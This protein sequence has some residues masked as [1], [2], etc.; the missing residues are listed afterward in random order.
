MAEAASASSG[1]W[2]RFCDWWLGI[3]EPLDRVAR[4]QRSGV[5]STRVDYYWN[6]HTVNSEPFASPEASLAYLEWR[7][8]QYPLFRQ[9]MELYGDHKGKT[10]LDYG[11]GPGNDLVGFLLQSRAD[12]VIG[13]DVSAKALDLARQRL[14]LHVYRR[15]RLQLIQISD[16]TP[17]VPLKSR[18][19]DHVYCEGVLH[20]TSQPE[21]ILAEFQRVLRPGGSA[22]IMVYNRQS[23][24][25]HLYT[26]YMRQ[27]VRGDFAGLSLE[28]AFARNTDGPHCPISRCYA[29][30]EFSSLCQSCGFHVQ[31]RGGYLSKHELECL[32]QCGEAALDDPRLAEEHR[33]FLRGLSKDPHGYP[34]TEGK[35]AGIGGTYWLTKQ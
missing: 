27:V 30:P 28:E 6:E 21:A 19:V 7:F 14:G 26:A 2:R 4:I 32:D 8:E 11:C 31:Y 5:P 18:S 3:K 23:V 12:K 20:H 16:L 1:L 29:W 35:H 13:M 25:V 15:R 9:F 22:C 10:V 33:R 17:Q 24:W 34:L